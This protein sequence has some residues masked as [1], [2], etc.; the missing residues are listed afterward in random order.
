MLHSRNSRASRAAIRSTGRAAR[1]PLRP[2][3][4]MT[5]IELMIV[6]A[7]IGILAMAVIPRIGRGL[8]GRELDRISQQLRADL[9]VAGQLAGRHRRPVRFQAVGSGGYE[10]VDKANTA[11]VYLKRNFATKTSGAA[12]L[13]GISTLDFYPNG[14]VGSAATFPVTMTVTVNGQA[15]KV[16]I[17]RVGHVRRL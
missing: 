6:V 9:Q 7:I 2:R 10:I 13:G 12:T 4:G 14:M 8:A 1:R 17:T 11:T 5:M 15:R 3:R 16:T